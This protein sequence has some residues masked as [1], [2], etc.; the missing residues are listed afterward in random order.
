MLEHNCP[1][2]FHSLCRQQRHKRRK[3]VSFLGQFF[4]SRFSKSRYSIVAV[5]VH[6]C[7]SFSKTT[8]SRWLLMVASLRTCFPAFSINCMV[9][10]LTIGSMCSRALHRL[11]VFPR[12]APVVCFPRLAPAASFPALGA[13]C[14]HQQHLQV[15]LL[16]SDFL[17][18]LQPFNCYCA[19]C[20]SDCWR[21]QKQS[22]ANPECPSGQ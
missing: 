2:L 15:L 17:S 3:T 11:N 21:S 13:G 20:L 14:G 4:P 6:F 10:A 16:S 9:P 7:H 12:Q 18:S 5:S 1:Y 19:L 22:T 8:R